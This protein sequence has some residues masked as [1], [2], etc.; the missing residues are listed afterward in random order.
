MEAESAKKFQIIIAILVVLAL[1]RVGVIWHERHEANEVK[2]APAPKALPSDAYIVVPKMHAYDLASAKRAL[3]GKDLWVAA[4]DQLNIYPVHGGTPDTAHAEG[5]LP[6]LA[7]LHVQKVVEVTGP[8]STFKSGD[9][10]VHTNAKRVVAI[11]TQVDAPAS[12][13]TGSDKKPSGS[14]AVPIGSVESGSYDF[15]VNRSE[16]RRV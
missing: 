7:H 5:T 10:T 15:N 14:F 13:K 1:V 3:E 2:P 11:V 16:E 9:V 12:D 4:G 8:G 6:A